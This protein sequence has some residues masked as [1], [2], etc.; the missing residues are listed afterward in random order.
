[1]LST[2]AEILRLNHAWRFSFAG[3]ILRMPTSMIGISIILLVR[4]Q[5]DSYTIAGVV[6]AVNIIAVA[7]CAPVL[8]RMIDRHGQLKIMGPAL[9]ISTLSVTG[10]LISASMQAPVPVLL[11]LAALAGA[12]C[13]SPGALVRSRW[14]Q[15]VRNP[16]QLTVAY[17][18]EAAMDELVYILGPVLATVL[19]TIFH[20]GTGLAMLIVFST[21][22][23]IGFF[24]QR[25]S[26]PAPIPYNPQADHTPV[27]T[28]PAV[29][30]LIFTYI[31][32]GTMFGAND[33][34]VVAFTE[35]LGVP[36][37]SGVLLA[38][39]SIGSLISALF[40][41]ARTWNRPLWKLFAIGIVAM[42]VGVTTYLLAHNLWTMAT[43]MIITGVACAP[44]M[45]NV[46]MIITKVV[47]ASQLTEG[48]TW[49]S[50]SLNLGLSI[51]SAL[52]GPAIDATDAHGGYLVMVAA[53]WVM[54]ILMLIGLR[55]LKRSTE[56]V[57]PTPID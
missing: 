54:V 23:G 53:A 34:S 32:A 39:F 56:K 52:A 40:Y 41:G 45:T 37:M 8:A 24:S 10:L 6:A 48:L 28:R 1:M 16:K 35:Q 14:S 7:C 21:I 38:F 18:F 25:D 27:I 49:M 29:I 50:T 4:S 20:P 13:G 30:V 51:G 46:N 9:T 55:T 42:A 31:G 22:G 17:A 3:F 19:G 2:Y 26:E 5:Y 57:P 43:A 12:T 33:V 11:I 15:V 36:A 44:T 47:P